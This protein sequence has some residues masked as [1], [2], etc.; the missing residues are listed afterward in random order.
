MVPEIKLSSSCLRL[1]LWLA[2]APPITGFGAPLI[3]EFM[4][5]N[6]SGLADEDGE[7]S[8]WIEIQNPDN[9]P[10]SLTGYHLT[11]DAANLDKWTFPAVTLNPLLPSITP[12]SATKAPPACWER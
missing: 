3:T 6:D 7:F 5:A 1:L 2:L 12:P 8:D 11:D 9:A 10:I 4:A